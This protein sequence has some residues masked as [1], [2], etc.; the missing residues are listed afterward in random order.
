MAITGKHANSI[1]TEIVITPMVN[2]IQVYKESK[3]R[4]KTLAARGYYDNL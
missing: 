1:Y 4:N 2:W 3:C